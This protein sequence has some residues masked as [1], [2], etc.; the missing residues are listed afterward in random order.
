[1]AAA[2]A[3]RT[4][5]LDSRAGVHTA[6]GDD[7]ANGKGATKGVDGTVM[8]GQGATKGDEASISSISGV[9]DDASDPATGD[10]DEG[11]GG[12]FSRIELGGEGKAGSNR[13]GGTGP[14]N[15]DPILLFFF[16]VGD[17][18]THSHE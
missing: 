12:H 18:E 4:P 13:S 16:W 11:I 10:I 17:R 5:A 9:A 15:A 8:I 2:A 6:A 14:R 7:A 1:M 3:D